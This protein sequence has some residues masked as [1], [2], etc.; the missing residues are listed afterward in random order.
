[1]LIRSWNLFH[2]NSVPPQRRAFLEQAVRLAA[3][4]RPDV[5]CLQ[6]VPAWALERLGRW[7]GMSAYPALA[8]RPMFGP[9]PI[10]TELGRRLTELNHGLLRS[11]FAGQGNAI[12]V[13]AALRVTAHE[14][15]TLN[16]RRFRRA[17]ARWL[18]LD[19]IA[20]IAW[21]KERRVC[22][23]VRV[24]RPGGPSALVGNL[25]ATSYWPDQRLPDAE[26]RRAA[27]FVDTLARPGEIVVLAGDFNVELGRSRT[28]ADLTTP[29]WGFAPGGPRI[30]H[31][32]VRGAS[33]G[34]V[35]VWPE[36]RR[37]LDGTLV[38]DHAPI[39]RNV[40]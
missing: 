37:R 2:G 20:R 30:D 4:D 21:A 7:S 38:S 35:T 27:Q 34:D 14:Q 18:G 29:D 25:H 17:Q 9:V 3:A 40:E 39:E 6:E 12:L 28:L 10:P 36:E 8:A 5:V 1:V 24:E 33:A 26:L 22:Q 19:P 31:I 16:S 15:L 32:L 13:D 23:A 11:A